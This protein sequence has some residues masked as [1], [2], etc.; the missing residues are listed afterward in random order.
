MNMSGNKPPGLLPLRGRYLAKDCARLASFIDVPLKTTPFTWDY[1]INTGTLRAQRFLTAVS[2]TCEDRVEFVSRKM[3]ERLWSDS[4]EIH[5]SSTLKALAIESGV[6]EAMAEELC[7][8]MSSPEVKDRLRDTTQEVFDL[9]A[10]G[11]PCFTTVLPGSDKPELFFGGDRIEVM[12]HAMG[13]PYYG[14]RPRQST[15][16]SKL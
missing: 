15:A 11:L 3:W 9:G 16:T 14:P 5:E 8:R 2:M 7:R 6:E 10:F 12:A 1:I 4:E 13:L